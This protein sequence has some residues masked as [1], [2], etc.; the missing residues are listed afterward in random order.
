MMEFAVTIE[1]FTEEGKAQWVL[2]IDAVGDR[3]LIVHEDKSMHW[4][5]MADCRFAKAMA[6]DLPKPVMIVQPMRQPQVAL[7]N[8]ADRRRLESNGR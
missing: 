8:R 7:P 2:A 1:G 5:P 4:H 3:L 6:P